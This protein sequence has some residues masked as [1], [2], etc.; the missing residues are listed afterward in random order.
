MNAY[1]LERGAPWFFIGKAKISTLGDDG[2]YLQARSIVCVDTQTSKELNR[3]NREK[4]HTE[5][6]TAHN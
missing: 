2:V 1:Y 3:D 4:R 6:K 5:L